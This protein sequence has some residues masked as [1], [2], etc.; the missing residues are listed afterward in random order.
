MQVE[1][2]ICRRHRARFLALRAPFSGRLA[3][4]GFARVLVDGDGHLDPRESGNDRGEACMRPVRK[5]DP[6]EADHS[7]GFG[8]P[9]AP[10]DSAGGDPNRDRP[11]P[12][13]RLSS[14]VTRVRGTGDSWL[15]STAGD[16]GLPAGRAPSHQRHQ[17]HD[18][19]AGEHPLMRMFHAHHI[20]YV[21]SRPRG[22][23]RRKASSAVDV[24]GILTD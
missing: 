17:P 12:R 22:P 4:A 6:E 18:R 8:E 19:Q 21:T 23:L 24:R 14:T 16:C 2:P 15:F 7:C 10:S 11:S 3:P 5:R 20:H 9:D 13:D 1:A